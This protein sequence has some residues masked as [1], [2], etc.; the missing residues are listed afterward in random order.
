MPRTVEH[1]LSCHRAA[2]ALK[3]AGRPIWSARINIK[4]IL[5]EDQQN[6]SPSHIADI[7]VR[8]A[9]MLRSGM[10][11]SFFDIESS[12][13]DSDFLDVVEMME[14]CTEGSLAVDVS[15]GVR[16]VEVFND[17]LEVIYDWADNNRV[18]CG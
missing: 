12:D 8:I 1:I 10:P 17:W 15:N 16:P 4:A 7:S 9:R 14:D 5:R 13:C 6:V 2:T 11:A 3:T 18:W